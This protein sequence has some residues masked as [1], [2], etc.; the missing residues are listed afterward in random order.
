[1]SI[2][3]TTTISWPPIRYALII[4]IIIIIIRII[5]ILLFL[6]IITTILLIPSCKPSRWC[7][8]PTNL[9]SFPP[10]PLPNPNRLLP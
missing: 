9:S 5:V 3:S 10:Q 1:M 7:L 4:V 2:S 8:V 6:I